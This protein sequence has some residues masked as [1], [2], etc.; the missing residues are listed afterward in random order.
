MKKNNSR[1]YAKA[2]FQLAVQNNQIKEIKDSFTKLKSL[3]D[4]KTI[5]FFSNPLVDEDTKINLIKS[6]YLNLPEILTNLLFILI[7]KKE[8][9]ILP[10]I[11][12]K[13]KT[14]ILNSQNILATEVISTIQLDKPTLNKIS[15][16]VGS[17]TNKNILLKELIDKTILGG[18]IIKAGDLIIDGS[19]KAKIESIRKKF[20]KN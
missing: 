2:L 7:N 11:E 14:E 19:I 9:P 4:E 3:Y 20:I 15:E 16:K 6:S 10:E 17:I 13:Y 5:N 12:N 18:I 1:K 8:L